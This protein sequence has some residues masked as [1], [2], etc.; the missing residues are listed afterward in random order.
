MWRKKRDLPST[1]QKII[2][3]VVE[4][5]STEKTT[6]KL[7]STRSG[8]GRTEMTMNRRIEGVGREVVAGIE[9]VT[10]GTGV[11]TGIISEERRM[12]IRADGVTGMVNERGETGD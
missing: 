11:E 3:R 1:A 6:G 5:R 4:R 8:E 2:H 9:R 12:S 7:T 10:D